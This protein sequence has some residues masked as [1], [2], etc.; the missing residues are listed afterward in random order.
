MTSLSPN[1]LKV[2]QCRYLRRK[3]D[4][5]LE[6]PEDLFR[7]VARAIAAAEIYWGTAS[8]AEKWEELFYSALSQLLFLPNSPTLMN[9]GT[10]LNQLSACFVLPVEDSMESIFSTLKLAALIQ[11]SGGGT[12]FNFSHLRP[13]NDL[14]TATGGTASGPVSFMK[15]FDAATEY[16]KQGGKRRGAN[17]GILNVEHPDIEEFISTKREKGV[18]TNFNIS[19][20]VS[21]AFMVAVERGEVW[22]LVHPN[23]KEI[24]KSIESKKLWDDIV[25]SAW[26][27][28][29]PGLIFLDTINAVNPIPQIGN[30]EST[31]P[32]G[33]VPLLPYESCN[34]A[35]INLSKFIIETNG[36]R[37]IDWR[38][39]EKI[40]KIV[41]RFL[42]NVI[43]VNNY[44]L[45]EI[46]TIVQGNRKIG[47]GV[48]GWAELLILLEIPYD[49][50][51]AI[52]LGEKLMQFIQQKSFDTS[53]ELA[54]QR[55]VFKN[56]TQS[57]Y[58]P[59]TSIRNATRLS[60]APTGTISILANT[61]SSIEPLFAL[62]YQRNHVLNNESLAEINS[63]FIEYLYRNN[64]YSE[65]IIEQV[66]V[67]GIARNVNELPE[68]VKNIFKTALEI[69]PEWH[70]KH[71]VV[72]QK[73]TDNA[74]SKTINLTEDASISTVDYIYRTAWREKAKGITIFRYHS[75]GKQVLEKGIK[76]SVKA[77]KVCIE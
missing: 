17:M 74:V 10:K 60:I 72:F 12:G 52:E 71:Q 48:M 27:S 3:S 70:L 15:I 30:I 1:A 43:E 20:G 62:A 67:E 29:D 47:L 56:W 75:K 61:S 42:D 59:Q 5:F 14:V 36:K 37:T 50:T 28:G 16:I 32:C 55:G 54:A 31:N 21:D 53:I 41:T 26:K 51:S 23:T 24:V 35:S 68:S 19:V 57:I 73:Y 46:K 63:L 49:S 6:T 25:E 40:V 33:E 77:C 66:K 7:R 18:L 39:L 13:Q 65:N 4:G 38:H 8:D 58:Y 2:L 9:A 69:S 64:L 11:Q 22:N 44:L 45:P 76:S 34:L